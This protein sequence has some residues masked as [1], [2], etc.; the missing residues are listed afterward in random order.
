MNSAALQQA[1]YDRLTGDATLMAMVVGVY[2]N[3][4]QADDSADASAFPYLTLGPFVMTPYDTKDTD[5]QVALVDV[6]IWS[7]GTSDLA[8]RQIADRIYLTLQKHE[9]TVSG[10]DVLDCRF[11][12]QTDFDDPDGL[13][14][15]AVLTFRVLYFT[16]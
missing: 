4:P 9:L 16:N 6:H 1:V 11:D 10:T 3:P 12:G 15:H 14:H 8:W 5:G 13:T 7:R 2:T